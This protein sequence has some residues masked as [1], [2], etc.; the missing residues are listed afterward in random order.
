MCSASRRRKSLGTPLSP[1]LPGMPH[2]KEDTVPLRL[3]CSQVHVSFVAQHACSN[4]CVLAAST[5]WT[6]FQACRDWSSSTFAG[7]WAMQP[8]VHQAFY[9]SKHECW[10][11]CKQNREDPALRAA[12][13]DC[14]SQHCYQPARTADQELASKAGLTYEQARTSRLCRSTCSIVLR[15]TVPQSANACRCRPLF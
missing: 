7:Y 8:R 2:S 11:T 14:V 3:H 1:C 10:N 15:S 13:L 9:R 12:R 5:G 6:N 4:L